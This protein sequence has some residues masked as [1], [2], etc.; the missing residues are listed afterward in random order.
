MKKIILSSSLLFAISACGN[1]IHKQWEGT[2]DGKV[3][4]L[5]I[6]NCKDRACEF[7]IES[8]VGPNAHTCWIDSVLT[9]E[10]PT[11]ASADVTVENLTDGKMITDECNFTFEK[12]SNTIKVS[13]NGNCDYSNFCGLNAYFDDTY[14]E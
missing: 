14:K 4:S 6:T 7:S 5:T 13:F 2:Y 3:G 1:D 11:N 8:V 12:V 9:I 10:S